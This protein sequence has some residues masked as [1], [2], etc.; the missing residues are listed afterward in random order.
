[1][2]VESLR[3][4]EEKAGRDESR[5][6]TEKKWGRRGAGEEERE[7]SAWRAEAKKDGGVKPP[8]QGRAGE[9]RSS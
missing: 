9:D 7:G 6:Y 2:K 3:K 4:E 1:L 8:L 5:P